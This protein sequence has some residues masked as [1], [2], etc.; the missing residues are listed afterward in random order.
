M[1]TTKKR[2]EHLIFM[3][4][5]CKLCYYF[6]EQGEIL[7]QIARIISVMWR[8]ACRAEIWAQTIIQVRTKESVQII[9]TYIQL[10]KSY[11][12][13]VVIMLI[14]NIILIFGNHRGVQILYIIKYNKL[15]NESV[16]YTDLHK[17]LIKT[18]DDG[19]E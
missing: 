19:R 9:F 10:Q 17:L 13:F 3:L 7:T 4:P 15:L 5:L 16:V 14:G 18:S 11:I 2:Y 8:L 6:Q 12:I 1:K